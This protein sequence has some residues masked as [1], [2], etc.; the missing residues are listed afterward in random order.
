MRDCI[1]LYPSNWLYNASV[2]GFLK[3]L[4]EKNIKKIEE[5]ISASEKSYIEIDREIFASIDCDALYRRG[6]IS[7]VGN[8][9]N[10]KN[11][12]QHD[13]QDGFNEFVKKLAYLENVNECSF[14]TTGW[15]LPEKKKR[16]LID[17]NEYMDR[18]FKGIERYTMRFSSILA[19]SDGKF[20]NAF[21]DLN[22]S[23]RVCHL[24]SYLIIHHHLA[25]FP[26]D[27]EKG[28]TH[29]IFINAPSFKIMWYLN[30]FTE[31]LFKG[32]EQYSIRKMLGMS[33]LEFSQRIYISLGAWSIMNIEMVIKKNNVIDYY[34]LPYEI[35]IILLQKDIAS[36][37]TQTNEP[38][39]LELVLDGKFD[40]LLNLAHMILRYIETKDEKSK[41]LNK[42]KNKDLYSLKNLAVILPELYVKINKI[43]NKGVNI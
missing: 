40:M 27:K 20:P 28:K 5:E 16:E 19:P 24:C 13:W 42:I 12:I 37:I 23:F 18:F 33:L 11:Y 22:Q 21:W 34:S 32:K 4:Y 14:C 15:F 36:L 43:L 41:L 2:I 3:I 7:I 6:N 39:V 30:K 1:K 26:S 8:S 38:Y 17:N 35:S 29:Q 9:A 25:F 31:Q 10:Y